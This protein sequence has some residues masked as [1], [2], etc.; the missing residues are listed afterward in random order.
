MCRWSIV[1]KISILLSSNSSDDNDSYTDVYFISGS[2]SDIED[3]KI[4]SSSDKD[5]EDSLF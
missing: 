2:K 4:G 3:I 5:E 1:T